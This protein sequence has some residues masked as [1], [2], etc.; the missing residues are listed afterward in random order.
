[1]SRLWIGM[2]ACVVALGQKAA[3]RPVVEMTVVDGVARVVAGGG[4]IGLVESRDGFEWRRFQVVLKA[5]RVAL[6][7]TDVEEPLFLLRGLPGLASKP[8]RT[9]FDR[10]ETGSL[11]EQ[12]PILL[13]CEARAYRVEV[14]NANRKIAGTGAS[15]LQF[16]HGGKTQ[17]LYRWEKGLTDQRAEV[18]WAGDLD[19][20]DRVDLVVDHGRLTLYLS[21]WAGAGQL[22]GRVAQALS[23]N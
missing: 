4:W 6:G 20:D 19:G 11:Y 22:V 15:L 8:V 12:N 10:S 1:M 14:T 18:V 7:P 17:T 9:C 5:G 2:L 3:V 16:S 23:R 13:T 21:S